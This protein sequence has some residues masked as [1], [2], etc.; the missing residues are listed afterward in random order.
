[1]RKLRSFI[2]LFLVQ[3]AIYHPAVSQESTMIQGF[4]WDVT[5]GGVWWDSLAFYSDAL[6]RAGFSGIWLPPPSKSDGQENV[7]YTP[8]DYYD[9]GEFDSQSGDRTSGSGAF[10]PTKYG[11]KQQL[12]RAVQQLK[13]N[14]L[15]VYLDLVLNHRSGGLA[16]NNVNIRWFQ[17]RGG[18][19]DYSPD[20]RVTFTA[21]PLTNGSGRVAWPVGGGNE[22]FYANSAVNP[23]NT[24]DFFS[25]S[26]LSGFHSMYKNSFGYDIA[27][28]DGNGN[29]LPMGDSLMIWG[30]WITRELN[31]D[32][33]RFDFVKGVHPKYFT[34]F[35]NYGAMNGKFHVHELYDG[36]LDRLQTYLGQ[37]SGTNRPATVF[38]F[39]MRFAYKAMS[40]GGDFYNIRTWEN[41]GLFNRF[42][43][44]WEQIVTFVENHDFDRLNYQGRN[45]FTDG[46]HQPIIGRKDLAYAHMLTHPGYA[47]V[48]W[49]DYFY[50]GMRDKI[51][52]LMQ[53]RNSFSSGG[54][55][56][57]TK[58]GNPAFANPDDANHVYIAE[59]TG[60]GGST[61][62]IVGINKHS[63]NNIAVWVNTQWPNRRLY[64][65]SGNRADTLTVLGDGRVQI[66]VNA[67]SYSVFVPVEYTLQDVPV[68]YAI[69]SVAEPSGTYFVGREISPRV[70]IQNNSLVTNPKLEVA[71][72]MSGPSGFSYSDSVNVEI[73]GG[74]ARIVSFKPIAINETGTYAFEIEIISENDS[75]PTDNVFRGS[76]DVVDPA[77]D[78]IKRVDGLFVEPEYKLLGEKAN[79][80]SGF[81][82]FK[83]MRNIKFLETSDS[84][85]FAVE[86]FFPLNEADGIGIAIDFEKRTGAAAGTPLGGVSGTSHFLSAAESNFRF[87]FEVDVMLSLSGAQNRAVLSVADY[88]NSQKRGVIVTPAQSAPLGDGSFAKGPETSELFPQNS[89]RYAFRNT[90]NKDEGFEVVIAKSAIG[91]DT[92][93][94]R[95]FAFVLSNTAYFSNVLI[96]GDIVVP[97]TNSEFPNLGFRPNFNNLEGGPF[98][99]DFSALYAI[100]SSTR[101]VE[102]SN[103]SVN[104]SQRPQL[105]WASVENANEYRVQISTSPNFASTT[106]DISGLTDTTFTPTENLI[107]NQRYFWRVKTF[108]GTIQSEWTQP[109]SFETIPNAP[110]NAPSLLSPIANITG[111]STFPRL[112]WSSAPSAS[113]FDVEVSRVLNFDDQ[114]TLLVKAMS[115]P[116][117]VFVMDTLLTS[118][119]QYFWRVRSVN[120]AGKSDWSSTESF[121][122]N[123]L[124]TPRLISPSDSARAQP[125][126]MKIVWRKA[127]SALEYEMQ[128]SL[129]SDY[130]IRKTFSVADTSVDVAGLMKKRGYFWRVR[131]KNE[132]GVGA[133]SKS[134]HFF[135]VPDLPGD[136]QLISPADKS[137]LQSDSVLFTW[138]PKVNAGNYRLQISSDLSFETLVLDTSGVS[139]TSIWVKNLP[140]SLM[141]YWRV[142]SVNVVGN[143]DWSADNSFTITELPPNPPQLAGPSSNET[144]VNPESVTF[145]WQRG[146]GVETWRVQISNDRQFRIRRDTTGV[147]DTSLVVNGLSRANTYYWRVQAENIGGSSAW[148]SIGSFSTLPNMPSAI[149]LTAPA[150]ESEIVADSVNFFWRKSV[151]AQ[152]YRFQM[153]MTDEFSDVD[154]DSL[155][156]D[157]EIKNIR[158]EFGNRYF[159]R[160][161]A[162]NAAGVGAWSEVYQFDVSTRVS[163]ETDQVPTKTFLGQNYPNPFN[164]STQI[165]FGMAETGRVVLEVFSI[166]G[167][168]VATLVN[169]VHS[170]GMHTV[171]FDASNL[172]SGMYLYR[173]QTAGFINTKKLLLIK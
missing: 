15:E 118:S 93:G 51:N 160:V 145:S 107:P 19:S 138:L 141:Y 113:S 139:N 68:D 170:A 111:V 12:L 9:L 4:Y 82:Q 83:N 92:G 29:N 157:V 43:V 59:R 171:Q 54:L 101:L 129:Y 25:E 88:S 132:N 78:G 87:D 94:F 65:V 39:N 76:F 50:Y 153:S 47:T 85:Y 91:G 31:A 114:S 121:T 135:T 122:T 100:F 96:P 120:I 10:I 40:D 148:S 123:V 169:N 133:W 58:D 105:L 167:R 103:R 20:G 52:R 98:H 26:Q 147:A 57:L 24:F 104:V 46:S 140:R 154:T 156:S 102:P 126:T 56:I 172:A 6:G 80:N 173:L 149:A 73:E 110:A 70:E 89:V 86:T 144:A 64:D 2:A 106:Y 158:V 1:M 41:S 155:I 112:V 142:Q 146:E 150:N 33:Y 18:G 37:L 116:D 34:T 60:S 14:G 77:T 3:V 168:K 30:D 117:T 49:R 21:F 36:S 95:F 17:N 152:S 99:S 136:P 124:G 53:I 130:N 42:G 22:F 61:G 45:T 97:Q 55:R 115:H 108:S 119:T 159:W 161:Q 35:L 72:A 143:S 11:T 13:A 134:N 131:A 5:P 166:D 28:H 75:N 8:Y 27:L 162:I 125:I 44:N 109:W 32:G 151:G 48:W 137:M 63:S 165:Q 84:I 164:P 62:L 66:P 67:M 81:G 23:E 128:L 16:E 71:I 74:D 127:S 163:N 79:D 90:G 38:D 69:N 7:G